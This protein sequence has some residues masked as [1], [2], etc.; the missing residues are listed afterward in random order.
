V[1]KLDL[2][3]LSALEAAAREHG[4]WGHV[5]QAMQ[6]TAQ[7]IPEWMKAAYYLGEAADAIPALI[8]EVERRDR[9]LRRLDKWATDFPDDLLPPVTSWGFDN[10]RGI[11]R[12]ARALLEAEPA[13]VEEVTG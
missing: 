8:E 9:V 6:A 4:I 10:L 13:A 2:D 11:I 3:R 5:R 1:T 7:P 12:E